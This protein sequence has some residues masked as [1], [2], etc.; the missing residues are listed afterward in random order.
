MIGTTISRK[1]TLNPWSTSME[2]AYAVTSAV[3]PVPVSTAAAK[4]PRIP[5]PATPPTSAATTT[6]TAPVSVSLIATQAT[7]AIATC[8]GVIGA[9]VI[10][11]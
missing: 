11:W 10:A 6:N 4:A 3:T 8:A 5:G 1:I 9:A 7:C 2:A